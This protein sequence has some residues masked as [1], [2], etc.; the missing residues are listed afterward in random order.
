MPPSKGQLWKF[1]YQ[2]EKQNSSQFKA[3]CKGC[4][5]HH[6]VTPNEAIDVDQPDLDIEVD[7]TEECYK[8]GQS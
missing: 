2:G 8:A 3:Y 7:L 4:I 1:F 5:H 6:R